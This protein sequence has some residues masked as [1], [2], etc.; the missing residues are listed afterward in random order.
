MVNHRGG[1]SPIN[2]RSR[3]DSVKIDINMRASEVDADGEVTD[4]H[5]ML[6]R[7]ISA[8]DDKSADTVMRLLS[9]FT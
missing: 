8:L 5:I 6:S 1:I 4:S 2:G 9:G 3:G 7:K